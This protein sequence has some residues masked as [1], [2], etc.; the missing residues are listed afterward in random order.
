MAEN[1]N[2]VLNLWNEIKDLVENLE[3]DVQ[4]NVAGTAAAGVR[5]RAGLR[6]LKGVASSLVK[7]MTA[8][9][10]ELKVVKQAKKATKA[11]KA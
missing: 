3:L 2:E 7:T 11:A 4:K 1:Q 10:K 6:R 5:S 9:D 8:R